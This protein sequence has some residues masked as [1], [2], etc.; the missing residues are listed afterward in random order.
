[1]NEY[2][3]QLKQEFRK[4]GSWAIWNENGDIAPLIGLKPNIVFIGFNASKELADKEDW[5]NFH[6]GN[7]H[8]MKLAKIISEKEFLLF[9]GA[10]TTDIIKTD[11]D[12]DSRK[13]DKILKED[14]KN[15]GDKI[16]ENK[17]KIERE[18]ELLSKISKNK[19][20]LFICMGNLAFKWTKS[21]IKG[22]VYKIYHY[23]N[24]G[25]EKVKERIRRDLREI[26]KNVR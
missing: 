22:D 17:D 8:Y 25:K 24:W 1:M 20:L 10:Y 14:Q 11:I 26:I 23:S 4:C 9:K 21:M 15:G 13:V 18:I 6:F 19:N 2:L 16:K 12:P 3:L 7:R 5:A